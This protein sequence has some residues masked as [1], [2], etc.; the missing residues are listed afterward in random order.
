M[1]YYKL[2]IKLQND[3]VIR[4]LKHDSLTSNNLFSS[5][6]LLLN[7]IT[8]KENISKRIGYNITLIRK[9]VLV[10]KLKKVSL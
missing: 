7:Q 5:E 10:S 6:E 2:F 1:K 8:I 4:Y 3:K 9:E